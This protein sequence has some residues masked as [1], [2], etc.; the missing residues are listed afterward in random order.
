VDP[1]SPPDPDIPPPIGD[2]LRQLVADGIAWFE[3]EREVYGVQARITQRAAGWIAACA[4]AALIL[5]QGAMIALV[6]GIL[7]VLGPMIGSGWATI[8]VVLVCTLNVGLCIALIR[9]KLRSIK[10]SWRARHDG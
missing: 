6:V 9:S 8:V 10:T 2:L 1:V 3:A 5:A 4:F 7:M